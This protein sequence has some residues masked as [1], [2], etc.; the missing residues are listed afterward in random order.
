MTSGTQ[1]WNG[2]SPSFMVRAVVIMMDEVWLK[3]FVVVH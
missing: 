1:K 3:I 2:A